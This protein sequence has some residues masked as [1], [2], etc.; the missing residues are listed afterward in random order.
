VRAGRPAEVDALGELAGEYGVQAAY[1]DGAGEAREAPPEAVAAALRA[2]G[3][4]LDGPGGAL[5][6]LAEVRGAA[7]S[8]LVE[9]VI[10]AWP[11]RETRALVRARDA[12]GVL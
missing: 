9:P 2:L 5:G 7:A 8:R 4:P 1:T 6:A 12:S 3:A 10:V 11:G